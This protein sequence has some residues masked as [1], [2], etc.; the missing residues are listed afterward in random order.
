MKINDSIK[1]P[2]DIGN[3][4]MAVNG[5]KKPAQASTSSS[6]SAATESVTL[7][8]LSTQMKTLEAK[9]A[10]TEVFD[11]KK[12]ASIKTAIA[13]GQFT[14]DSAKIADGLVASVKD[15]LSTQR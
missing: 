5:N 1:N 3:D 15:F 14:V 7:S 12:V 13:S 4:K 9:I 8:T 2:I 10:N 11:A 6:T